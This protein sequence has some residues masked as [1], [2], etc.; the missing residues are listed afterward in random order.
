MRLVEALGDLV[1]IP[2]FFVWR[3]TWEPIKQKYHK[4]PYYVNPEGKGRDNWMDYQ[5]ALALLNNLRAAGGTWTLG[6]YLTADTGYWFFDI[7][8]CIKDG[9]VSDVAQWAYANLQGVFSEV[10]SSGNGLHF[11]GHGALPTHGMVNKAAALELYTEGRG[12]AFSTDDQAEGCADFE[13][14]QVAILT[15]AAHWFPYVETVRIEGTDPLWRGPTDDEDLLRRAMQSGSV[16]SLLGKQASF[17]DLWNRNLAVLPHFYPPDPGSVDPF[18]GSEADGA[19]AM[20]LAFWTGRDVERVERLMR[21]SAL[22]RDKWDSD[23]GDTTYL[24]HTV[25]RAC[26]AASG[27]LQDKELV[28]K[29]GVATTAEQKVASANWLQRVQQADEA[30][31]RDVV[32]PG[33]A[34]DRSIEMLDRDR[35][36]LQIKERLGDFNIPASI[37]QCRKMVAL[38]KSAD[39]DPTD[40]QI[41]AFATEHVYV[42]RS[43]SFFNLLT[44]TE[45]SRTTFQ[46]TYNRFM[47]S[48]ANGDKEDAAKWCLDQWGTPIVY[49]LMYLP[50]HEPVFSH[51]ALQ[52]GNL[53]SHSTVP[54]PALHH[55]PEGTLAIEAFAKHLH[56]FCGGRND[57][58]GTVLAWMA[59]NV[60][61][62]GA[63]VRFAPILKGVPGD[64]KSLITTVMAAA[65]GERNVA[66]VGP[67]VVMNTGGFTDWAHGACV[68]AMEELKMEGKNRYMV[69]NAFKDNVTNSRVTINRKGKGL[70]PIINISNFIAYTNFVDAVPLE[71]N[72]RRWFVVFS[73]YRTVQDAC[74]AL[75][76]GNAEGLG[77]MFDMIFDGARTHAGEFRKWLIEMA[78]PEW[79]KP[80]GH[81]PDTPEKGRMRSSG[82]DEEH[83]I[84]RQVI[85]TGAIGVTQQAICTSYLSRAMRSICIME[86]SEVPKTSKLAKMLTH[87]GYQSCGRLIKWNGKP[88]RVWILSD[89]TN[90][91][92]R[93]QL[94][95]TVTGNKGDISL[96]PP[97][98]PG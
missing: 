80:N 92:I 38:A 93:Y 30:E 85:A 35:L 86:G 36:A 65:M 64:G 95:T 39:A 46:A 10:S 28:Q 13:G 14:C 12:I 89:M 22:V 66:T 44:A 19:L 59:Y 25:A 88:E 33:I 21:R 23:R 82:E 1:D 74:D 29:L 53:Y 70:L 26:A 43:D 47:K 55:S 42:G 96:L 81:A 31:L 7:D 56:A 69:A 77:K 24:A 37:G 18:G 98:L 76:V 27:V 94:D 62:P 6:W 3:L 51:N 48:K 4:T 79:F 8:G 72:D 11:I 57:V 17:A 50:G 84:A 58:Y 45:C 49:D 16:G 61:N 78:I 73:P 87:L 75:G 68:I 34:Q 15:A 40:K 91:Q 83:A 52:Y 63:K 54:L 60:Q 9:V 41:P 71:D 67:S 20:H 32:V 2:Q 97:L 90:D 5:S